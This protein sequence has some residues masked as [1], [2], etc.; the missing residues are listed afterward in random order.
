MARRRRR[1]RR[2]TRG[3]GNIITTRK[4][5]T[6]GLGRLGSL[7]KPGT[8]VGA[9][10]PPLIGGAATA[11]FTYG[12]SYVAANHMQG[13]GYGFLANT[14][15]P[16]AG[17]AT[18]AAAAQGDPAA[19]SATT[20]MMLHKWAPALGAGVT[21]LG[22]YFLQGTVGKPASYGMMA[23]AVGVGGAL[24]F[25]RLTG[26]GPFNLLG[27]GTVVPEYGTSG[28][29]SIVMEPNSAQGYNAY[30]G[31]A[32][33]DIRGLGASGSGLAGGLGAGMDVSAFGPSSF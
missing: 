31:G 28:L 33:V 25:G 1:M 29:G 23:G 26:K 30:S 32:S 13:V 3:V 16:A 17:A 22:S 12:I 4:A 21:V 6:S 5:T 18:E 8:V 9:V 15:D 20:A 14:T 24:L 27:V 11:L 10:L 2:R 7:K 19:K